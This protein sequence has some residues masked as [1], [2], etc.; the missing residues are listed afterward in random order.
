MNASGWQSLRR[1]RYSVRNRLIRKVRASDGRHD[2]TF[3]CESDVEAWRAETLRTKEAGTVRWIQNNVRPAD[4]FFDIGANIGLYSMLA[5]AYVGEGGRVFSFEPH[6]PNAVSLMRNTLANGFQSRLS[7]VTT[8]LHS[9]EG[10]LPFNYNATL[11]GSSMSQLNSTQTDLGVSFAPV[12]SELKHATTI[13]ALIASKVVP[14][15]H[16]VKMD[17]DGNEP[18][19]LKGMRTLLTSPSRPRSLQVEVSPRCATEID[20]ILMGCNY[21]KMERHD[22][23]AGLRKI[24]QGA[25]AESIAYNAIYEPQGA[26]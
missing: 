6:L 16:V 12:F 19:I 4:V 10:F 25:P 3:I 11:P 17:V 21:A 14:P 9:E 20:Q 15:P 13:D 23:D 8:A 22:T 1:I 7:L 18:L 2:L 5:A 24:A 26:A